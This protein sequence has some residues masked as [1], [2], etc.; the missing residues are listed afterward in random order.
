MYRKHLLSQT[1]INWTKYGILD[2]T[3]KTSKNESQKFKLKILCE[4]KLFNDKKFQWQKIKMTKKFQIEFT[5]YMNFHFSAK[6]V[7]Q[8]FS[9]TQVV[10]EAIKISAFWLFFNIN[11]TNILYFSKFKS[12]GTRPR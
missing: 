2:R 8:V 3:K 10:R 12:N 6:S 11:K 9:K 5:C 7:G 1:F 4:N